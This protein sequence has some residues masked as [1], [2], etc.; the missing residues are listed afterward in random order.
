MIDYLRQ[1]EHHQEYESDLIAKQKLDLIID[2]LFECK[3][4]KNSYIIT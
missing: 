2:D 1:L 4:L 3:Y